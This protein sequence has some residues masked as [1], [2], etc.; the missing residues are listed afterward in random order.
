MQ[1]T[2]NSTS[3]PPYQLRKTKKHF[4]GF[5]LVELIVVITI[6]A[7]LGTIGFLSI[8]GYS[9]KA[10]DSA[11]VSDIATLSKSLD[12]SIITTGSYPTPDKSFTV[13][14]SG[15]T[16][17]TQGTIG[18]TVLQV[19]KSSI[20]GGGPNKKPTDPLKNTEYVYSSLKFGQA[21]QMKADFENDFLNATAYESTENSIIPMAVADAGNP[22][23]AYIRGN[24]G[25]LIAKTIVGTTTYVLAIPSIITNSGTTTSELTVENNTLSGTLLFNGKPLIYATKYNP[26]AQTNSGVVATITPGDSFSGTE[27]ITNLK[28]AYSSSDLTSNSS[29]AS[30][31]AT[32]DPQAEESL[33]TAIIANQL[34]GKV[35]TGGG[36]GGGTPAV[37]GYPGCDSADI[38]LANGQVWAAC[39]AGATNAYTGAALTN[40]LGSATD[41]NLAYRNSL[42]GLYQ[43]WRND[44]IAPQGS[45]TTTLASASATAS[46][47]GTTEFIKYD[48]SPYDWIATQNNNLWGGAS[49][50]TSAGSFMGQTAQNKA[51]MQWPCA[52]DYHVPTIREWCDAA[53]S[54]SNIPCSTSWHNDTT[55]VS[56]LKLSLAGYRNIGSSAYY[57]QGVY[58]FY[59]ASS[60]NSTYGYYLI[61]SS[62]Q[63][64]PVGN[65]YRAYGFSVRCLKN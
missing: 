18:D 33:G 4:H 60:P 21:Y 22:T 62:T 43:W 28:A 52:S 16:I 61:V 11:R 51:L 31:I 23:I 10:R 38:T 53:L 39:N 36:S 8:G 7:I 35:T 40:C 25:W 5:T 12:L 24:Y 30:L 17:W 14:Y 56:T 49:T 59:W 54:I 32:T 34:G 15:G 37:T 9:S 45:P 6:L 50:T 55:I 48:F 58:G 41:C 2:K 42:G 20:G 65:N 47:A 63:V 44:N 1:L 57:S 27:I 3:T 26:N 46:T 19:F 64:Y 29:I 13:T